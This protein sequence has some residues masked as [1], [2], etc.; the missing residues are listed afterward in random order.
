MCVKQLIRSR[1][2]KRFEE[3]VILGGIMLSKALELILK[4]SCISSY[5]GA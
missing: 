2:L 1:S 5:A 4:N 3:S